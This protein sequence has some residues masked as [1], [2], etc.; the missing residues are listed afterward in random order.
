MISIYR[1]NMWISVNKD[2]VIVIHM[3]S[4]NEVEHFIQINS[5]VEFNTKDDRIL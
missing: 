5:D 4:H 3:N 2:L 1:T